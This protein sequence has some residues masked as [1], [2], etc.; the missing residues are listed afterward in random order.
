MSPHLLYSWGVLYAGNLPLCSCAFQQSWWTIELDVLDVTRCWPLFISLTLSRLPFLPIHISACRQ[1]NFF[2]HTN[3]N[4][5]SRR[6]QPWRRSAFSFGPG[7]NHINY[8]RGKFCANKSHPL[9]VRCA[10]VCV[11]VFVLGSPHVRPGH[12]TVRPGSWW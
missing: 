6:A 1:S 5:T 10:C 4:R 8:T 12:S 7:D 11:C 2:E 3:C 9:C